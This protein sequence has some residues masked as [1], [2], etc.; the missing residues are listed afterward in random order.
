M[1][2]SG[3]ALWGGP[4]DRGR[5]EP[6]LSGVHPRVDRNATGR[7]PRGTN[8]G[9]VATLHAFAVAGFAAAGFQTW[10]IEMRSSFLRPP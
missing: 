3:Q 5:R 10:P 4:L 1:R 6:R 7:A 2:A 8:G 9:L